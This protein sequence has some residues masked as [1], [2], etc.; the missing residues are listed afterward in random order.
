[1]KGRTSPLAPLLRKERGIEEEGGE[2][3]SKVPLNCTMKMT[4]L[5]EVEIAR[6]R[7]VKIERGREKKS[8]CPAGVAAVTTVLAVAQS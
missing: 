8:P 4:I 3:P 1:M 7:E 5:V 6:E 2:L